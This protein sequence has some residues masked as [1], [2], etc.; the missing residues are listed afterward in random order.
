MLFEMGPK[1][2]QPFGFGRRTRQD[3]HV[4]LL[5]SYQ[6][7][8]SENFRQVVK[9]RRGSFRCRF[10]FRNCVSLCFHERA[11]SQWVK[12]ADVDPLKGTFGQWQGF[13][14]K[15]TAM[16]NAVVKLLQKGYPQTRQLNSSCQG[17]QGQARSVQMDLSQSTQEVRNYCKAR[18]IHP[19]FAWYM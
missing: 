19:K 5:S 9:L 4:S 18:R 14:K 1:G 16:T 3:G 10:E 6:N 8:G 11:K 15:A 13:P 17:A 2:C 12:R 7:V